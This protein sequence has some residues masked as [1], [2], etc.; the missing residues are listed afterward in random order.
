VDPKD[1]ED[2]KKVDSLQLYAYPGSAYTYIG[3]NQLR[4]GKE[5]FRSKPV[6]QALAYGL[7]MDLVIEKVIFGE[8]AKQASHTPAVSWA[9]DP[10]GIN[11]Y[12]YDPQTARQLLEQDGWTRGSDGVYQK[13]NQKLEFSMV[14]NSGNKVRENLLQIAV[15]QYKQIG[16]NV[17]PLTE[18][19][20]KLDER[21]TKTKDP[22][23]G[24]QGGRD[25]DAVIVGWSLG[26]DPD[27]YS[28]WHSSQI[29][30]PGFNSVG[31][32][33]DAADKALED[34]RTKCSRDERK[35]AYKVFNKQL[36]EDQPYNFGYSPNSLL[37]VNKRLQGLDPGPFRRQSLW[38]V[39]KWWVKQ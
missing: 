31:Y 14:T 4:G 29:P 7:N 9:Y 38:N 39:D 13:D 6:R 30:P 32:R 24:D 16:V 27:G 1:V 25:F 20:E 18:S 8:G 21:T 33:N 19:F 2:L 11:P 17:T 15:E 34:G 10:E 36:N 26:A 3:W 28:I 22:T 23:Y 35:A 5:F 37:F 12:A